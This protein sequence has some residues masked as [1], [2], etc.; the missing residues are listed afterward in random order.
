[1]W[2]AGGE[3]MATTASGADWGILGRPRAGRPFATKIRSIG[4]Q[5]AKCHAAPQTF[6]VLKRAKPAKA[7][8][9]VCC[10]ADVARGQRGGFVV[11]PL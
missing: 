6:P 8:M 3:S 7:T 2:G 10:S 11:M 9:L 4:V 5:T 1:M